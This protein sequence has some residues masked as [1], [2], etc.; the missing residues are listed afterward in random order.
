MPRGRW[1]VVTVAVVATVTS[2]CTSSSVDTTTTTESPTVTTLASST[3]TST[4]VASPTTTLAPITQLNAPEY[5]IVQR[6]ALEGGGDEVVALLDPSTYESL[7][8]LDVFDIVA[9]IVDLFPPVTTL[10]IVD[11]A[12][13]A[14]TVVD[15]DASAEART[16][17][18]EHYL[19]RLENGFRIIYLGP[20]AS[21]GSVV[22]GS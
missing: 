13:A 8:D 7:S 11:D 4:T 12:A 15:P 9:E 20:F 3:T 18:Q 6:I 17:L 1:F 10:H 5:Q 16:A 2:A 19:A 22:L 21:S 14:N